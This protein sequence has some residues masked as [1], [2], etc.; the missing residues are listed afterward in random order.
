MTILEIYEKVNIKT[1]VE[2]RIFF[3]YFNDSV[4]EISTLYGD[5]PY[6]VFGGNMTARDNVPIKSLSDDTV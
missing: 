2:Q 1:P 5:M 4:N 6:A 3:N